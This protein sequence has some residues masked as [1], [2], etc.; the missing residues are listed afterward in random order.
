MKK[1]LLAL[2]MCVAVGSTILAGCGDKGKS[3]SSSK[4]IYFLNFK[5]EIAQVYDKIAKDYEKEKGVKVKVVTAASGTYEQTLKSEIAKSDAPTIFQINGPVGYQNWKDYCSDLKDSKLYSTLTD[6]TLAVK[7][8]DGVYGIPYAIEGYGIIYNDAI[9]KKY[10][11][12]SDKAVSISS[13]AEITN[14]DTLKKVVDD[15]TKHKDQLG[16]KGVFASTSLKSGEQWRWQTH[17]ANLPFYYEFKENTKYDSPL[18]AGL[19]ADKVDFKYSDNF[20]NIF[21][22]YINNSC[23]DKK[24]L[25]TKSVDDSMSDFALGN[26]AMVQNGNWA[27][28]QIKGVSGN[29]VKESDV[30][31][32]P[33]YTGVSGED[34]Q[35]LCIGTENFFAINSKVSK[36]KQQESQD[37]L[38][39]LFSSDTGKKYVTNDLGFIAPFNTFSD[40]EKPSDP[41]AK[42]VLSWMAKGKTNVAWSFAAFPSENFKN[43]FG[44]ALLEYTQ[45]SKSWDD[46]VKTV[47]ESWQT[48]KANKK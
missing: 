23:T 9:M 42:D 26:A 2:V 13:T 5:P 44:D 3:S 38:E 37:F 7:S 12:L 47:K 25:G 29:T 24:L 4:E 17:L 16:I 43:A 32:L 1:K 19:A 30:K 45:G 14:Y 11:A 39:W 20:K 6:K 21:D 27:W 40:S 15:M 31:Y 35:G 10:F 28:A 22:L 18:L 41:L 48:E 8:G 46:V 36:E 34:N 33:I